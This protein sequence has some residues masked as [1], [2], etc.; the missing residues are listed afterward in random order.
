LAQ[1]ASANLS[2]LRTSAH[3]ASLRHAGATARPA[4]AAAARCSASDTSP[5]HVRHAAAIVAPRH[6]RATS[7][8]D[9]RGAVAAHQVRQ[10]PAVHA[11]SQLAAT[12]CTK[13][14]YL[15]KAIRRASSAT[16]QLPKP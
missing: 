3:A 4:H 13:A 12:R 8:A 10:A 16:T 2:R 1:P 11:W 15:P 6:R 7:R 5:F 9:H 14:A